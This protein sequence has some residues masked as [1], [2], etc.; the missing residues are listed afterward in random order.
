MPQTGPDWYRLDNAAKIYPA[1][2]TARRGSV[3]RMAALLAA[4][5]EPERLQAALELT[6]G[7]FPAVAVRL[8][9]GLFWYYFENRPGAPPVQPETEFVCRPIDE[10]RTRGFLYRVSYFDR[11]ISLEVFHSITDGTGAMAFLKSLIFHYLQ[12][13]GEDV[14]PGADILDVGRPFSL[15]EVEDSFRTYYDPKA[16][17]RAAE[18]VAYQVTGT[19]LPAQRL[20]VTHGEMPL[21][22]ALTLA[23]EAGATLTEYIVAALQLAIYKA[24]LEGRPPAPPVR[25]QVPVNLRR[26]LRSSTLRNFSSYIVVGV[27]GDPG[28][29]EG[30]LCG[31][32]RQLRREL[33]AP[34]LIQR[35]SANVRAERNFAVRAM[36]LFMKNLA[37]RA[38]YRLYGERAF[39]A[40]FSNLGVVTLPPSMAPHVERFEFVLGLG[41]INHL[42]VTAVTY[43]GRLLVTFTRSI[44][45]P[46][47]EQAFFRFLAEKGLRITVETNQEAP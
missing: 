16:P 15:S 37:M 28:D 43:A 17:A 4:P 8:R 33:N 23:R 45:E 14:S 42:N 19:P 32:R 20:A 18:E 3:F 11:R 21:N 10:R 13:G 34:A 44:A 2:R 30:L 39:T 46:D 40:S 9:R 5:V 41:D 7:R 29:F 1:I 47:V 36:P 27:E 24:R 31:V 25:I 26:F 35:M 6:A 22:D 12:L 38:A